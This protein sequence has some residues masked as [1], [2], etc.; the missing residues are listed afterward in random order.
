MTLNAKGRRLIAHHRYAVLFRLWVTYTPTGGSQR[1]V[2]VY[3][4]RITPPQ[5]G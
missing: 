5:H 3:G 1:E 4:L 2:G